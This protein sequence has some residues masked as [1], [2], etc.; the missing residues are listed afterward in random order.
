M[1]RKI[2]RKLL[3]TAETDRHASVSPETTLGTAIQRRHESQWQNRSITADTLFLP[4]H[5]LRKLF[6]L[7][8]LWS[9]HCYS[10]NNKIKQTTTT[11]TIRKTQYFVFNFKFSRIQFTLWKHHKGEAEVR[12]KTLKRYR[13]CPREIA[14]VMRMF[15]IST[16]PQSI[17]S[18]RVSFSRTKFLISVSLRFSLGIYTWL[19]AT[20]LG[21]TGSERKWKF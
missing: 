21:T 11:K 19:V 10:Q 8:T 9:L 2:G 12:S 3:R 5:P 13:C 1:W 18:T 15:Y 6:S 20:M 17:L 4:T 7:Q 14:G 16:A